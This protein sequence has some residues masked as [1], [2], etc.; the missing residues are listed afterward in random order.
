MESTSRRVFLILYS[1]RCQYIT[2]KSRLLLKLY[3]IYT[4]IRDPPSSWRLGFC[5]FTLAQHENYWETVKGN[6][7]GMRLSLIAS[8]YIRIY[9]SHFV[10]F[11][12]L[13]VG[14]PCIKFASI[15]IAGLSTRDFFSKP[16]SCWPDCCTK[17]M[18]FDFGP[19]YHPVMMQDPYLH[20]S[21]D[22]PNSASVCGGYD[23]RTT[24]VIGPA[25][26]NQ[27]DLSDPA[28]RNC[29]RNF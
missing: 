18:N 19:N 14:N 13:G 16:S 11:V 6:L 17:T 2:E 5:H 8:S 7:L 26:N 28:S 3:Y 22:T 27:P 1:N 12:R 10:S 4:W 21:V 24:G 20:S 23:T 25:M 29:Y 9:H 15:F